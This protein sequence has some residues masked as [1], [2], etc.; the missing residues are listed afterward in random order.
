MLRAA[1]KCG[2]VR[3]DVVVA[4][5]LVLMWSLRTVA[6]L[7]ETVAPGSW[8]R[9]LELMLAGFRPDDRD[10]GLPAPAPAFAALAEDLAEGGAGGE[11]API[12]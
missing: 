10:A 11:P 3:S 12:D 9:A 1:Q 5:L 8:Q 4:D 2:A 7:T 6:E